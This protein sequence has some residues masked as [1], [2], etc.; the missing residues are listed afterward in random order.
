M[1]PDMTREAKDTA[2]K[3]NPTSHIRTTT[4]EEAGNYKRRDILKQ[5]YSEKDVLSF[6]RA[7]PEFRP[8]PPAGSTEYRDLPESEREAIIQAAE[9]FLD[10]DWPTLTAT[11]FLNFYETGS[12]TAYHQAYFT[13]LKALETLLYAEIL[14]GQGRFI[15]DIANGVW[16]LCEQTTWANPAHLNVE[17]P[18]AGLPSPEQPIVALVAAEAAALLATTEYFFG[19]NLDEINPMFRQRMR[20]EVNRQLLEPFLNRT[21]YWWMAYEKPFTN[22]WSPWIT[23][24]YLLCALVFHESDEALAEHVS[25]AL[26]VLDRFINVYPDDGGCEEGPAYW[27][28]AGGRMLDCLRLLYQATGGKI[29]IYDEPLIREMGNF[30]WYASINPPWY[31]NFADAFAKYTPEPGILFRY[32]KAVGSENL[33]A[34][35]AKMP[36]KPFLTRNRPEYVFL[37]QLPNIFVRKEL[38]SY[39]KP[40]EPSPFIVLD[41]LETV[42]IRESTDTASG[43]YLAA[44]GGYNAES[45]NHNDVGNFI[46]FLDGEP[47]LVDTGVGTYTSKTFS[48]QRYEIWSMQSSYHNL[49]DINK[50]AQPH[51]IQ[52]RSDSFESTNTLEEARVNMEITSAYPPE[53][54]LETYSRHFRF[55]RAAGRILL[56]EDLRFRS[57]TSGSK[58]NEVDFHFMTHHIP[59]QGSSPGTLYLTHPDTGKR[60]AMVSYPADLDVLVTEISLEDPRMEDSWGDTLYR[61][62]LNHI[63]PAGG[64][65]RAFEF[66]VARYAGLEKERLSRT[67]STRATAYG[68]SHK[69]VDWKD[70]R[71]VG[72]LDQPARI[73]VN[74]LDKDTGQWGEPIQIGEG[75]SN[76]AGPA[77]TRDSRGIIHAVFGPHHGPFV[78]RYTLNAGDPESWSDPVEFGN[79]GTYPSLVCAPDDTLH[80]TYRSSGTDPWRVLYQQHPP[81]GTWS[82]PVALFENDVLD[83]MW[84]G[85]SIAVDSSGHLH[86]VYCLY[87]L[88]AKRGKSIH[89]LK[90]ED[91]GKSWIN[92]D[93]QPMALPTQYG[94]ASTI[95]KDPEMDIR[96]KSTVIGPDGQ[97][98]FLTNELA[99][100][101]RSVVLRHLVG[102]EWKT[103]DLLPFVEAAFPGKE[104]IDGTFTFDEQGRLVAVVTIHDAQPADNTHW[105]HPSSE[106][107]LM[108]STDSG[109]S[110]HVE[111]V[112]EPDPDTPS[113]M[114]S[115]Q[116]PVNHEPIASPTFL[117]TTGGPGEGVHGGPNTEVWYVNWE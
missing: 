1:K 16:A 53:A 110:F 5:R 79:M 107:I 105:G 36:R 99:R 101:P 26:D 35:A 49:P 64:R 52:W 95:L 85:H 25:K 4:K 68:M 75:M 15:R 7:A 76:H 93:R 51:M 66:E 23:S 109:N 104:P 96:I 86:L 11:L 46:V 69:I 20:Y 12:N 84:T 17:F 41:D 111:R 8:F 83:Y 80:L 82:E 38:E 114:G 27:D 50:Q 9:A 87:E 117:Y 108:V 28:H 40:F 22:N 47:L 34:F 30:M 98:W 59:S 74:R 89:Y 44:K 54:N 18:G 88:E 61:I 60:R 73:M 106:V 43:F 21:D 19:A 39:N 56:K 71:V 67:G 90:S 113:W 103:V 100:Q 32:G 116:R 65:E 13:R 78:H 48:E 33:K 102:D 91:G 29:D 57:G 94:D 92:Q 14:E 97:P 112:S 115:M 42:Y 31:V 6:L 3:Y 63:F 77:L 24:N 2:P 72:W 58:R 55:Q 37:R 62:T 70:S 10:Y 81:G 45:H